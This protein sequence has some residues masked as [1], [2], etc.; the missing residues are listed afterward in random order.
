M[1][2]TALALGTTEVELRTLALDY[3]HL[4]ARDAKAEALLAASLADRSWVGPADDLAAL[5][6]FDD[7]KLA[8]LFKAL[9]GEIAPAM[10]DGA[11]VRWRHDVLT[12]LA[13]TTDAT[14]IARYLA[15]TA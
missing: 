7:R 12:A 15:T 1:T 9:T 14:T 10:T 8:R 5:K 6:G 3:A 11:R 13:A 4:R 2:E